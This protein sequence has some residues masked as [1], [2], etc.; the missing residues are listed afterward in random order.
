MSEYKKKDLDDLE[1]IENDSIG[2]VVESNVFSEK[3]TDSDLE[4]IENF[5]T[6]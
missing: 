6:T 5:K 3:L 2:D 4:Y 1:L